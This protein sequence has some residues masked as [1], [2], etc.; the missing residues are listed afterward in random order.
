MKFNVTVKK[1]DSPE[2]KVVI[3]APSRFAV[4]DQVQKEGGVVVA[5]S[6]GGGFKLP[7]WFSITIGSGVKRIEIIRM[8][9]NMSA[10]INAGLSLS[11]AL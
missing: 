2:Q 6:E 10:M 5:V 8:A 4:Y 1:G 7:A 9:K 3:D 11:R